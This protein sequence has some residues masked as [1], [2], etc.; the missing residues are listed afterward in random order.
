[1]LKATRRL[2]LIGAGLAV[3]FGSCV[4]EA[5]SKPTLKSANRVLIPTQTKQQI[6]WQS[7]A[8]KVGQSEE[9]RADAI[10]DLRRIPFL[11]VEMYRALSTP[12]RPFALEVI[13][14]LDMRSLLPDLLLRASTDDDGFTVLAVNSMMTAKNADFILKNYTDHLAPSHIGTLSAPVVVAMMEPMARMNVRLPRSTLLKLSSATSPEIRSS[15][16]YYLRLMAIRNGQLENL[17][18][19][20]EMTRAREM[21]LR[22]QAISA[23]AEIASQPAITKLSSL[24]SLDELSKLCLREAGSAAK[25]ACLS[26]LA[27]GVAVKR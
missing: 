22:L 10:R 27:V 16:L 12:D 25:E 17:D 2:V 4:V 15:V 13:G 26:F 5:H 14:A 20:T 18:L 7:I 6:H 3:L 11:Q 24:K 8:R 19:V 21:Q 9:N 1:M 23:S